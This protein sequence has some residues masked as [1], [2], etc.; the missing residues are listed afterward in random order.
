MPHLSNNR[1][2]CS[3]RKTIKGMTFH[4][5]SSTRKIYEVKCEAF[6]DSRRP[7][8]DDDGRKETHWRGS[9][10]VTLLINGRHGFFLT[11]LFFLIKLIKHKKR[12][13]S[14]KHTCRDS[15]LANYR[16]AILEMHNRNFLCVKNEKI[17]APL[18][19][20]HFLGWVI[21]F[22]LLG[23]SSTKQ[24]LRDFQEIWYRCIS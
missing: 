9:M 17:W 23:F 21:C 10:L 24:I 15:L 16:K 20:N 12:T 2:N 5:T 22:C 1:E 3:L 13:W 14:Q 19:E 6:S 7:W 4:A 11:S 8:S 18:D